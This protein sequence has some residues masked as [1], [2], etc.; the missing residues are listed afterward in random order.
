MTVRPAREGD[1]PRLRAV[2]AAALVEPWPELLPTAVGEGGPVCLV[3]G[4][5]P[6]GYVVALAPGGTAYLPE[7]AVHPDHQGEGHG[8]ALLAA[9]A[10]RL[11]G[12]HDHLRVTVRAVDERARSFYEGR[13]FHV[14]DRVPDHFETGE[15]LVLARPV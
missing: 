9:A 8:S 7:L 15:G 5:K 11:A 1:L 3:A 13:G 2:Q 14:V 12:E 4:T 6:V 10:D